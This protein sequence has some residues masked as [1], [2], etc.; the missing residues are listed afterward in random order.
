MNKLEVFVKEVNKALSTPSHTV[1]PDKVEEQLREHAATWE[2]AVAHTKEDNSAM[3][4][5]TYLE[6]LEKKLRNK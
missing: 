6:Q 3:S 2:E 1:E 4:K 5:T